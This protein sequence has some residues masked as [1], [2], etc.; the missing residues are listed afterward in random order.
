MTKIHYSTSGKKVHFYKLDPNTVSLSIFKSKDTY[1]KENKPSHSIPFKDIRKVLYGISSENLK[2]R[3]NNLISQEINKPWLF[4][5]LLLPKRTIDFYFES[6][7]KL[8]S[9]FYGINYF[10]RGYKTET[11]TMSI[12]DFIITKLKLK[13]ITELKEIHDSI[14]SNNKKDKEKDIGKSLVVLSQLRSYVQNTHS[15][16]SLSFIK[17]LLLYKK[18]KEKIK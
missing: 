8:T 9:W 2:R 17:V 4:L 12:S 18:V 5:S 3:Y 14:Y 7:E 13:L 16:N 6:E 11:E 15:F 1:T 10:I